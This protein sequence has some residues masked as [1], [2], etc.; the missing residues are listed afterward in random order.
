MTSIH[1][2]HTQTYVCVNVY[3]W[4]N[5]HPLSISKRSDRRLL[6]VLFKFIAYT[7]THKSKR[8]GI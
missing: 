5:K 2:E 6:L 4:I 8:L 3:F 7:V 1:T